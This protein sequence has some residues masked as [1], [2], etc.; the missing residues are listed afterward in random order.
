M[1]L[2]HPLVRDFPELREQ[3]LRLQYGDAEFA[4]LAADYAALDRRIELVAAGGETVDASML[5][6]LRE[7]H[8]NL[9]D[10]LGRQLKRAAGSCCGGCCG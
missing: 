7:E 4:R 5:D 6:T 1:Q 9:K 3:A 8:S 2:D 10:G